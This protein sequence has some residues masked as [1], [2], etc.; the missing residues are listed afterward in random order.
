MSDIVTHRG[1]A[2]Q[3]SAPSASS[4]EP[5]MRREPMG[6]KLVAERQKVVESGRGNRVHASPV[7][8]AV[9]MR[10]EIAEARRYRP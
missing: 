9:S 10:D 1:T 3:A 2:G 4:R 5:Q 6:R 7:Q 8:R